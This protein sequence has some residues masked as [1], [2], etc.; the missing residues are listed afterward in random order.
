MNRTLLLP[1][2]VLPFSHLLLPIN[3]LSVN[4]SPAAATQHTSNQLPVAATQHTSNQSPAATTQH[5]SNQSPAATT[6][7][8]ANQSPAA[9]VT[10]RTSDQPPKSTPPPTVTQPKNTKKRKQSS[11]IKDKT[12][13]KKV[14]APSNK[15]NTN[16]KKG[17]VPQDKDKTKKKKTYMTEEWKWEYKEKPMAEKECTLEAEV[18]VNL[19]HGATPFHIFQMVTGMNE[20]LEIIV[21]ETN[22]YTTQKGRKFEAM[23]DEIKVFLG[24]NVIMGINKL[25]SLENYWSTDKC[26]GSEKIQNAMPRARIQSI[27]Q[28]LHFSN[29]DNDYKTDKSYKIRPVIEHLK[30]VFAECLSTSL[31]QSVD[32]HI[33]K[34]KGRSSMKQYIKNRPIKRGF[35]YWYRC[36]S[37]TG[38]VYQLEMYQGRKEKRELNLGSSVVLDLW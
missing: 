25:P 1:L 20:L 13:K 7:L 33:C 5:T 21:T 22:R 23:E 37:E 17:S 11:M 12:K 10:K 34:F 31:F 28:N 15:N 6:Q 24:I 8:T 30:K 19:D 38:Y 3:V 35:K 18:F 2:N 27:L 9:V 4:Q 32:E 26:I 16:Q 14:N 29:N 36:D